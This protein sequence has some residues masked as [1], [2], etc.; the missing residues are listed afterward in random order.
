MSEIYVVTAFLAAG[1]IAARTFGAVAGQAIPTEG[2]LAAALNALPGCLIVALVCVLVL[3][4]GPNEWIAAALTIGVAIVSRNLPLT[5]IFGVAA[6][7]L[8]RWLWPL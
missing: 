6:I 4:G 8:L 2:R 7:S 3:N 1:T 5:M